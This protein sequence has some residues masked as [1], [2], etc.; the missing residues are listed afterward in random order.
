MTEIP[1]ELLALRREIDA[2]DAALVALI[3][4]RFAVA[5]QVIGIK[6]QHNL[7]AIIP[8]R[9]EVV[10]RQAIEQ[11]KGGTAPADTIEKIWRLLVGET[12]A[13]EQTKLKTK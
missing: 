4:K 11:S 1:K 9:V 3:V 8:E 10:V 12:I 2:I 13:Y 6:Q 5:D 7:P